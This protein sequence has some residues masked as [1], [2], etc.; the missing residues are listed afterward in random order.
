MDI[1]SSHT[2]SISNI[3]RG[4]EEELGD[5]EDLEK[6]LAKLEDKHTKHEAIPRRSRGEG[7]TFVV[8][9]LD[10]EGDRG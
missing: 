4:S 1:L 3:M 7:G 9:R 10:E 8:V 2:V 6:A 5:E